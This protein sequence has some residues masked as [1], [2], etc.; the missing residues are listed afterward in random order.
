VYGQDAAS[1]LEGLI[2][3]PNCT[4]RHSTACSSDTTT[5]TRIAHVLQHLAP[6]SLHL[7]YLAQPTLAT[8][9]PFPSIVCLHTEVRYPTHAVVIVTLVDLFAVFPNIR[10]LYMMY[11]FTLP[12]SCD[13]DYMPC[14]PRLHS[15]GFLHCDT[16]ELLRWFIENRIAPS[17]VLSIV[18]LDADEVSIVGE[19]FSKFGNVLQEIRIELSRYF[20]QGPDILGTVRATSFCILY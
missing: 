13:R 15:L 8:T 5:I 20:R 6:S 4:I 17:N 19:Y 14:P 9:T 3:N 11:F 18:D 1:T 2:K 7:V 16:K 12:H 10:E